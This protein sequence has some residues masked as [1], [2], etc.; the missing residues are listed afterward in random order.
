MAFAASCAAFFSKARNEGKVPVAKA[1][2]S[3]LSKPTGAAPG[4]AGPATLFFVCDAY[5]SA[6]TLGDR[7]AACLGMSHATKGTTKMW[8]GHTHVLPDGNAQTDK[9]LFAGDGHEGAGSDWK[10]C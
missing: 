5:L 10:A 4:K 3:D 2:V 9:V 1:L 6:R 7:S 8:T